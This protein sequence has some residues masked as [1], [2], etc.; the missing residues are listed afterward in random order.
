MRII[1]EFDMV[2]MSMHKHETFFRGILRKYRAG[3]RSIKI[4]EPDERVIKTD[5][6]MD[7]DKKKN[8]EDKGYIVS[9]TDEFLSKEN[10]E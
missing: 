4:I 7:E 8:L 10:L 6:L 2:D 1:V 9:D 5:Y 3:I